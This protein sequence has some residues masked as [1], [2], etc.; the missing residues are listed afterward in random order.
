MEW[1]VR[2]RLNNLGRTSGWVFQREVDFH[3]VLVAED[4]GDRLECIGACHLVSSKDAVAGLQLTDGL[5]PFACRNRRRLCEAAAAAATDY[6]LYYVGSPRSGA[7]SA[8]SGGLNP[9][10]RRNSTLGEGRRTPEDGRALPND[11]ATSP[12]YWHG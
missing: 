11:L 3:R 2:S 10:S 9:R 7:L 6:S 12:A 8:G 4:L 1:M 5:Q